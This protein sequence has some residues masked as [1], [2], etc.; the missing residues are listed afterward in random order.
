MTVKEINLKLEEKE[1]RLFIRYKKKVSKELDNPHL[2]W[3][4]FFRHC[5]YITMRKY[6]G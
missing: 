1:K 6:Y 3:Y 5:V 4:D 2:T